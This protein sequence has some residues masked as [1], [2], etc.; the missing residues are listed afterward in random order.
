M[1]S[2]STDLSP[3]QDSDI[4][5]PTP[6]EELIVILLFDLDIM[7]SYAFL[8]RMLLH[9][10]IANFLLYLFLNGFLRVAKYRSSQW[11]VFV[12]ND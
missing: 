12:V 6:N 2:T 1:S 5:D 4:V 11:Y 8:S 10:A 7:I 3:R 9:Q